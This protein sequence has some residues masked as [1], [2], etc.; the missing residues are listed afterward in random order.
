MQH[1][2]DGEEHSRRDQPPRRQEPKPKRQNRQQHGDAKDGQPA[3]GDEVEPATGPR[4]RGATPL[5]L[6]L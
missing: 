4:R 2:E 6:S 3:V 5:S 1:Q